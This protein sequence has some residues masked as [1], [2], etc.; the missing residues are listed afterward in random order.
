[1]TQGESSAYWRDMA[2]TELKAARLLLEGGD[3]H[4]YREVLF[5]CH[6]AVELALKAEYIRRMDAAAPLTHRLSELADMLDIAMT[7]VDHDGLDQLSEYAILARYGDR[8][9]A[10]SHATNENAIR[11]LQ[12][13]E[14]IIEELFRIS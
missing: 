1:M 3:A 10:A 6:L 13:S 4:L 9:W 14:T 2:R 5:H 7:S 11:W 8:E 12:K